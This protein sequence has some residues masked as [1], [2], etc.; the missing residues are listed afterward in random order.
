MTVFFCLISII[1][2]RRNKAKQRA[3]IILKCFKS[4]NPALLVKALITY[5]RPIVKYPCN[6]W[7]PFK[8]IHIDKL[9][10]VQR[11]FTKRLKGMY[12]LSY[13]EHLL[14]LG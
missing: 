10:H 9:E 2:I 1:L 8:L 5:V 6:V 7:L 11:Y 12:N 13:G 14:N 4:R 3:V